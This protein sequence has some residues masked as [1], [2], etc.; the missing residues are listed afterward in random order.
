MPSAVED[1]QASPYT[2]DAVDELDGK[3]GQGFTS[4]D[5]LEEIDI[6]IG[7]KPR[8][9]Y[10]SANLPKEYKSNLIN[11]LKNSWIVLHGNIMKCQD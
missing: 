8:P 7:D 11:L 5:E 6:G 1:E 2:D 4:A 10:I 9:T 3:L